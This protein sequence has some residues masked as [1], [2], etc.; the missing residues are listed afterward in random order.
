MS[1]QRHECQLADKSVKIV[2][3]TILEILKILSSCLTNN[4]SL[5]QDYSIN[6]IGSKS[7]ETKSEEDGGVS[8]KLLETFDA[9]PPAA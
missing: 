3:P 4:V 9:D 6:K 1:A 5:R 2:T 8:L 7:I